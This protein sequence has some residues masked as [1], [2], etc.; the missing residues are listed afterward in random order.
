VE[1]S[2]LAKRLAKLTADNSPAIFTALGVAG[3]LT[4]AYL[5]GKATIKAM[6]IVQHEERI[7]E[8][9]DGPI[10]NQQVVSLVWKQYI[11]P[12]G[13]AVVTIAC[14][15]LA[16]R[17]GSR[18]AA[19][20]AAAYAISERGFAE[21]KAKVIEKLGEKK[22]QGVRDEIAQ[23]RVNKNPFNDV[24]IVGEGQVL[25][26]D[27]YTGRYFLSD[28]E[29]IRRAVNDI[30]HQINAD[31]YASLSDFYALIGLPRTSMS[32]NMGWNAD[33]LLEVTYSA[34]LSEAGKPCV[35]IDF[36]VEPV[37]GYSRLQ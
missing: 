19:A 20:L 35:A 11:P 6:K 28:M 33:Q 4:T 16:N 17:I 8:L 21:Y 3:A 1:F 37:R 2:D 24:F 36:R 7:R 22:E 12:A 25:C 13:S 31:F 10:T 9:P 23:D 18:R 29:T 27:S 5:T 30:N 32:D 26:Y 15:I 34:V 14:I